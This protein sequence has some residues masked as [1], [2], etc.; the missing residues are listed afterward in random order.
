MGKGCSAC[1][2]QN[3]P[4]HFCNECDVILTHCEI[5]FRETAPS[6][7]ELV[8][9]MWGHECSTC[10]RIYIS[11]VSLDDLAEFVADMPPDL[12]ILP[13]L[14]I[15]TS[16]CMEIF[17]TA[18]GH[19]T[20]EVTSKTLP[21]RVAV[22][23]QSDRFEKCLHRITRW[24]TADYGHE[25][26]STL[27]VEPAPPYSPEQRRELQLLL[28]QL[29]RLGQ[30]SLH[31]W[32]ARFE[33]VDSNYPEG[34]QKNLALAIEGWRLDPD[35]SALSLVSKVIR[36][37][38]QGS[39]INVFRLLEL[40]LKRQTED[41]LIRSRSDSTVTHDQFLAKIRSIET[42]LAS[43]LR[44][45]VRSLSKQPEPILQSIWTITVPGRGFNLDEVFNHVAK[46]RNHNVHEP[47]ADEAL[48]LP[49][50]ELPFEELTDLVAGLVAEIVEVYEAD[51]ASGFAAT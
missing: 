33:P 40:V 22:Q 49:W 21:L 3:P 8:E 25:M 20:V 50:E 30:T 6:G 48:R 16:T 32:T 19:P 42:D 26:S 2:S 18:Y 14:G 35:R 46:L 1:E 41:E 17:V 43:R 31:F 27:L 39:F 36:D 38:E 47:K 9:T 12:K 11:E 28:S 15:Q 45:R 24:D 23:S 10:R 4:E 37:S 34:A 7:A 13:E 51:V 29:A 44:Q 5:D